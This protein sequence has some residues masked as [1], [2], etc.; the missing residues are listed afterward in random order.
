MAAAYAACDAGCEAPA[1]GPMFAAAAGF[2]AGIGA[3]V[4]FVV[5]KLHKGSELVY[6]S[7]GSHAPPVAVSPILSPNHTG[8]SVS[9][10]F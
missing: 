9:F 6:P 2:G 4:G 8:L 7:T 10:R 3:L 1:P 5:D